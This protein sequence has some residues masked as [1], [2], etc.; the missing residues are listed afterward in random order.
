MASPEG[1]ARAFDCSRMTVHRALKCF[2]EKG[3]VGL[4]P[5]KRGPKYARV[6][7][8]VATLRMVALKRQGL[9]NVTIASKLKELSRNSC[10]MAIRRL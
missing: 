3:L 1:L 8:E 2:E 6:L 4:V 10:R 7:G 5:S 9:S